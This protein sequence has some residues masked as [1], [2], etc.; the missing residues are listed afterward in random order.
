MGGDIML[1]DTHFLSSRISTCT[2]AGKCD[3]QRNVSNHP[4]ANAFIIANLNAVFVLRLF[5]MFDNTVKYIF[6]FTMKCFR[7]FER[8][9]PSQEIG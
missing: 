4:P 8:E 1:G 7:K 2:P 6:G 3:L 9:N 5:R